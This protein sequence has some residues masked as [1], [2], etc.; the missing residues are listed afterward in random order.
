[1]SAA[2]YSRGPTLV[3]PHSA[4][5][6]A[7]VCCIGVVQGAPLFPPPLAIMRARALCTPVCVCERVYA[8]GVHTVHLSILPKLKIPGH[9][10]GRRILVVPSGR[11]CV[12]PPAY[13]YLT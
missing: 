12:A 10:L 13:M 9:G 7:S 1:M 2:V 8:Q 11:A 5:V 6:S 4:G 3:Y